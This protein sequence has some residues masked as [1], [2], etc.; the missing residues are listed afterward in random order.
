LPIENMSA[1]APTISYPSGRLAYARVN[2]DSN[3]WRSEL[4]GSRFGNPE[5]FIHST[6]VETDI[7]F[8]PDG[9]RMV[10]KSD[11]TGET[12]IWRSERNGSDQI[13]IARLDQTRV[14][15]PRCSPD[16]RWVVFDGYHEGNSDLYLVSAE[17]G[18][19]KRLTKTPWNE[20]RPVFTVDG[21]SILFSSMRSGNNELWKMPAAGGEPVQLTRGGGSEAFPSPDGKSVYFAKGS[22]QRGIWRMPLEGGAPVLVGNFG[23]AGYW[24]VAGG[25]LYWGERSRKDQPG[26]ISRFNP[27]TGQTSDLIPIPP[28]VLAFGFGTSLTVSPD[29]KTILFQRTDRLEADLMLVE[30]FR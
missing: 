8:C 29:E 2:G 22:T 17:G 13:P 12:A 1:V 25:N 20:S 28:G 24:G 9:K 18:E 30:N 21:Q 11:R 16:G 4:E 14:G 23:Q 6:G 27:S 3:M 5:P 15:S 19:A 7:Q 10:F 26:R